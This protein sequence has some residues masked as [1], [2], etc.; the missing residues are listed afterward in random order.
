MRP[1]RPT[2]K[3]ADKKPAAP[4]PPAYEDPKLEVLYEDDRIIAFSKDPGV[5]PN[6]GVQSADDAPRNGWLALESRTF[7]SAHP[8][9]GVRL[10]PHALRVDAAIW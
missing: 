2:G 5:S 9:N 10:T 4:E 1:V 8:E 7:P 3:K 6:S